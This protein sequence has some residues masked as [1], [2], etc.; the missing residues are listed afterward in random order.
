M[1]KCTLSRIKSYEEKHFIQPKKNLCLKNHQIKST[2]IEPNDD[3]F[4]NKNNRVDSTNFKELTKLNSKNL[5]LQNLVNRIESTPNMF[6]KRNYKSS[7]SINLK[8]QIINNKL[9]SSSNNSLNQKQKIRI[10]HSR[11]TKTKKIKRNYLL[12]TDLVTGE[13]NFTPNGDIKKLKINFMIT[14]KNN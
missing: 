9:E 6:P 13:I 7:N 8:K 4:N 2:T 3:C 14:L 1:Q 12:H 5:S 11:F 10:I